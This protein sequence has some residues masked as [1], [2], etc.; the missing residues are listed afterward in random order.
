MREVVIVDG[1][2][3]P[4]ARTGA[5]RS[6]FK[7]IRADDLAAACVRE[8]LRRNPKIDPNEIEDVVFGCANQSGEQSLNIARMIGLLAGCR[9][10][11]PAPPSIGNAARG[12][13]RSTPPRNRS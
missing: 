3:T 1:V 2:R 11:S 10:R 9:S 4:I 6:Y 13:R 5:D 7:N 8:V 12:S